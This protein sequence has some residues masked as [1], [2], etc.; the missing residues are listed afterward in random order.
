MGRRKWE[1][2][3]GKRQLW[4]G[5]WCPMGSVKP[6][7]SSLISVQSSEDVLELARQARLQWAGQ[8]WNLAPLS[9]D[10]PGNCYFRRGWV[11]RPHQLTPR[12]GLFITLSFH[13]LIFAHVAKFSIMTSCLF[14]NLSPLKI[15]VAT[16]SFQLWNVA[17]TS[18][19]NTPEWPHFSKEMSEHERAK[20]EWGESK[21]VR[22]DQT[23]IR[24]RHIF[25]WVE[26][27]P[28][29]GRDFF[30]NERWGN[31]WAPESWKSDGCCQH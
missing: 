6:F 3:V 30:F 2:D 29:S 27:N 31:M 14:K 26:S 4:A 19:Q 25:P 22:L 15:T 5:Q 8:V 12:S 21:A 17:A 13:G 20:G 1:G 28:N 16:A 23:Q 11:C 10:W 9:F 24:P 7:L 18:F